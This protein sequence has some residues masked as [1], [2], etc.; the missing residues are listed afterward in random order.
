M[1]ATSSPRT[2][3]FLLPFAAGGP[4]AAAATVNV[5][6]PVASVVP[7][8]TITVG[9][10]ASPLSPSMLYGLQ[11]SPPSSASS[12]A[13]MLSSPQPPT[14]VLFGEPAPSPSGS[15][16]PQQQP[17]P[18]FL[19]QSPQLTDIKTE[20][21]QP[22]SPSQATPSPPLNNNPLLLPPQTPPAGSPMPFGQPS[23]PPAAAGDPERRN[24]KGPAPRQQEELCLVCGDRASG[25]HYNAL[26]CEGCK[27]FFRRSVTKSQKYA[28]K[29]GDGCEIDMYM[30]RKCQA[31]RLKKCYAVGM[32]SECVV[33]ESQCKKKRDAK[34]AQKAAKNGDDISTSSNGSTVGMAGVPAGPALKTLLGGSAASLTH[35]RLL[36]SKP[37]KPEEEELINRIVFYQDEY[38]NPTEEDLNRVYHVPLQPVSDPG[39]PGGGGPGGGQESESDRLFQHMTEMTILTVQLIVEF[40]KHLPGFQTLC[41]EDQVSLLKGCSSEVMM[42]RGARR[43]D[44]QRDSIIYATNYPFSEDNYVKAGLGN[45]ALFRFCRN[46]CKMKVD[47]AEYALITA[48]VI[49][50][51]RTNV[52]EPKRVEKIQEIYVEALQS[53]VMAKR[54][55]MPMVAFANLLAVLTELRSLGNNNAKTCFELRMINRKLPPFLAEIWDIK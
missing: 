32:R 22:Y 20:P 7:S 8:G 46:M 9:T 47:N 15:Q 5:P 27:G 52:K 21:M 54:K 25:Y 39:A 6:V 49:F 42:L 10:V 24:K 28:C 50:S 36:A 51:E 44:P 43:Y 29:Y 33:P 19:S 37:L 17:P 11:P 18:S 34:Q 26:A 40:S 14:Q 45:D 53:Y 38:E 23:A 1:S 35:S 2:P 13:A 55:K 4:A 16:Q 31:C 48:I 12:S 30:R 3:A 41:R